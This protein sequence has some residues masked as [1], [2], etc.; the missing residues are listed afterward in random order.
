MQ[1]DSPTNDVSQSDKPS[2]WHRKLR[3]GL[4]LICLALCFA[5]VAF[6]FESY[7]TRGSVWGS[8]NSSHKFRVNSQRGLVTLIAADTDIKIT[9]HNMNSIS[10]LMQLRPPPCFRKR[11]IVF[12]PINT[13]RSNGQISTRVPTFLGF[14]VG[15]GIITRV[16]A[17]HWF[18]ALVF[19][20][21][22]L[23][24]KPKPR[25]RIGLRELLVVV[26]LAAAALGGVEALARASLPERPRI[27]ISGEMIAARGPAVEKGE[28]D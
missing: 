11:T 4:A 28:W 23:L 6:W 21:L 15:T 19:G 5:S 27:D 14:G 13:N 1:P 18:F 3:I 8:L 2:T 26:T 25:L 20:T 7:Q 16:S 12:K 10:N 17:P 24:L 22:A 9:M